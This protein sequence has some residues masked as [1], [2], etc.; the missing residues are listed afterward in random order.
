MEEKLLYV[1]FMWQTKEIT[2]ERNLKRDT[3][4]LLIAVNLMPLELIMFMQK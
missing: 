2:R 4:S 1:D 3:S